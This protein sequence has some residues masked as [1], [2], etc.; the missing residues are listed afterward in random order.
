M[1]LRRSENFQMFLMKLNIII[2]PIPDKEFTD[3][4]NYRLI[5]LINIDVRE[6]STEES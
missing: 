4:G 2:L 5:F 1:K 3:K 6:F